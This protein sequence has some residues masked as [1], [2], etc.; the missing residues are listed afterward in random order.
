MLGSRWFRFACFL[1]Q[2][3]LQT[4]TSIFHALKNMLGSDGAG[5]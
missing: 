4:W 5:L 3:S 1:S 2:F